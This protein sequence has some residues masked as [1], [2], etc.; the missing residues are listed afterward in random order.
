MKTKPLLSLLLFCAAV[1]AAKGDVELL[2]ANEAFAFRAE[3]AD[4]GSIV[5]HWDI[6][7]GY[8]MYRDKMSFA[9][10]GEGA[11]A[12]EVAL[13]EGVRQSDALF[14]EVE[15]YFSSLSA[16]VPVVA[17]GA[18]GYTLVATGQG[19]N[20]PVGVC[21]PPITRQVAFAPAASAGVSDAG[22]LSSTEQLRVLLGEAF[23]QPTFLDVDDAFQ[24]AV[25][26]ADTNRLETAFTIADG[27]Y[28]YRD[29]IAFS[30]DGEV[31][32]AEVAL[33]PGEMKQDAYFGEIAVFH[34]DFSAPITL[35]R[36]TP[37]ATEIRVHAT[38]Q[39]CAQDGICYSP[40]DKTFA[41]KLPQ[42]IAGASA[43]GGGG[44]S[45]LEPPVSGD[46]NAAAPGKGGILLGA[47]FAGLLLTFTPCVLPMLP[48][49]SGVIAGQGGRIT[50]AKGGGL[51]LAYVLGSTTTYAAIGAIAGATGDQLQAYF[52][53]I[54][55]IGL[56]C[57]ILIAMA[58]SMFG[59][60][61][62]RA[63][64]FIQTEWQSKARRLSGSPPLVFALGAVSAVIV[65]ACVS[66][67][68]ISFLGLAVSVG[69]AWLGAQMMAAVALGMG[70][71]LIALG[72]GA[73]YLLPKAGQW[74][75]IINPVFGVLLIGVAI[76]LLGALPEVP[77]LLL[78]GAFF[79]IVSVYLG[80]LQPLP[81]DAGGWRR[82]V[83]GVGA[84]LLIW[85][86][87][88]L[89]GGFFGER[90][91]LRP[92]PAGL[93]A[94]DRLEAPARARLDPLFTPVNTL[95]ELDRQ[96]ARAAGEGKFV[97]LEYYADWCVDCARM[98][99]TTFRDP[100]V[101]EALRRDFVSLRIDVTDPRDA[102]GKALKKRF[103]VFGPPAVLL[104]DRNGAAL[105][106]KHFYGYRNS[107]DFHALITTL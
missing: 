86:V 46:A 41:L 47:F 11:L 40:V 74:M 54:W 1:N 22:D 95:T 29:K 13:P 24:L 57:A 65:G 15:V 10:T 97:L 98:E 20:L 19:C 61:T 92:L 101:V 72:V 9:I 76:Y 28:L 36:P 53:N 55:A 18:G 104:F 93:F 103:G 37:A 44:Q 33:P 59:L 77:V 60:F 8:Y 85:G 49:L 31:R 66:P 52:Q 48:I 2:P 16:R 14:G 79:V 87:A 51:A 30:S 17:D 70:V 82:F 42:I 100:R 89:V 43:D 84:V 88:A 81:A 7:D 107:A 6:A 26:V 105:K 39:G 80:A 96:F 94:G 62:I 3:V 91:P 78:W 4:D 25:K 56:L 90:N 12:G 5:A 73:G 68:L 64:S 75:E 83:K 99:E 23:E 21:Y 102:G 67:I 58:L 35:Q 38:Y 71:P 50:R 106:D 63:P 27:Y 32:L 34:H 45:P 69:D